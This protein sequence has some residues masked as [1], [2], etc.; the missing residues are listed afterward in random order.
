MHSPQLHVQNLYQMQLPP[1]PLHH[2]V[3]PNRVHSGPTMLELPPHDE[4]EH[5]L[6]ESLTEK[7]AL[8]SLDSP[9]AE[10]IGIPA[11][12]DYRNKQRRKA[13]ERPTVCWHA[14]CKHVCLAK[15]SS[16]QST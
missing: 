11:S 1:A 15:T 14:I 16:A 12:G 5:Q 2:P 6:Q 9:E 13:N 8:D 3:L 10:V 4:A 7:H